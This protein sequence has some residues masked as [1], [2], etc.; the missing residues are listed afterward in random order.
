MVDQALARA[1]EGALHLL[2]ILLVFGLAMAR[3]PL[4]RFAADAVLDDIL[5]HKSY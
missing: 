5:D 4:V 1:A 3:R 2:S